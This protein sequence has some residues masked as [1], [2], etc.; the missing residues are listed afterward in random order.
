MIVLPFV[1]LVVIESGAAFAILFNSILAVF[2]LGEKVVWHYDL[3]AFFLIIGG[4]LMIIVLSDYS[5]TTYT[6]D[7]IKDLLFS[8]S[9][10]LFMILYLIMVVGS[11]MQYYWHARQVALFNQHANTWLELKLTQMISAESD[12]KY[13]GLARTLIAQS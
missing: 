2:Y 1:D 7:T 9:T 13:P 6:P 10:F 8:W 5:D 3:P 12:S 11:V 4:C